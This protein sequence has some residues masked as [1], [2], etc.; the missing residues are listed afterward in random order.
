VALTGQL[1]ESSLSL[2]SCYVHLPG[3]AV[4]A[5]NS[6]AFRSERKCPHASSCPSAAVGGSH[7]RARKSSHR[8]GHRHHSRR[9]RCPHLLTA[10]AR[11][12]PPLRQVS[13]PDNL[14]DDGGNAGKNSDD[15]E[16]TAVG[17]GGL[18]CPCRPVAGGRGGGFAAAAGLCGRSGGRGGAAG[19]QLP[20]RVDGG[21]VRE[22]GLSEGTGGNVRRQIRQ[23]T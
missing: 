8:C 23:V 10:T 22:A 3:S 16:N 9:H 6:F 4:S 17:G 11:C 7:H 21:Q 2:R 18:L 20:L 12:T 15:G 1:T 13:G 14:S 19:G 5:M